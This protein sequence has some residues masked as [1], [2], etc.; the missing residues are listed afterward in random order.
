[1]GMCSVPARGGVSPTIPDLRLFD[2]GKAISLLPEC[3]RRDGL[4]GT[5]TGVFFE[6]QVAVINCH[7]PTCDRL[8]GLV[9]WLHTDSG[10]AATA[11]LESID[12]SIDADPELYSRDRDVALRA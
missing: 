12:W 9:G 7:C 10:V 6:G 4:P 5:C 11:Q 1:M 2:F 3:C 8:F